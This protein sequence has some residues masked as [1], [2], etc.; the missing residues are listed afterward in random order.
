MRYT[1]EWAVGFRRICIPR[2]SFRASVSECRDDVATDHIEY[3]KRSF[4]SM[5][6]IIVISFQIMRP[7]DT[8]K[9]DRTEALFI[10]FGDLAI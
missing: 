3:Q 2:V 6:K 5:N 7:T 10:S 1:R 4:M 8:L 9:A